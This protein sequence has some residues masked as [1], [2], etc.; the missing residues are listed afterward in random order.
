[1]RPKAP[2]VGTRKPP[3]RPGMRTTIYRKRTLVAYEVDE[4][5]DEVVVNVL[6]VFQ[7]GQDWESALRADL[8]DRNEG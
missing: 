2:R 4:S 3:I 6:G 7:G 5:G 8:S 1:M